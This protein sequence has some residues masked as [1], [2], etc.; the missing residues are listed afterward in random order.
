MEAIGIGMG[1]VYRSEVDMQLLITY[2]L[3][4]YRTWW[5][6]LDIT[7]ARIGLELQAGVS[8]EHRDGACINRRASGV[9]Q[10]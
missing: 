5:V 10:A 2:N 1:S 6:N 4:S 7:M 9:V 8:P 3:P